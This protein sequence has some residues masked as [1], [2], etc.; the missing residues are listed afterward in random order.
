MPR[1]V[2]AD[3]L[4]QIARIH[5]TGAGT[6]EIS[7]YGA[8]AGALN[9]IGE[10][11]KPR[12][13]CVPNLRDRGAGF[14]D[15]G[16]FPTARARAPMDWP[17]GQAPERGVIEIDDIPAD[18]GIKL[19]SA[20]I[21]R[22][23]AEYHLVLVTNY[24]D[25]VLL[26]QDAGGSVE[27]RERF[28]F[29]C[30]D[31]A[32]FFALARSTK[33]PTGL[34]MRFA[35]F[36]E[37]VLLHQA[38][39][40]RPEDVAFFL[41]SYA[42]DALA[43]IEERAAIPAFANLRTALQEALGLTFDGP[44]GEHLFRSTLVQTLFYGLF[45]AWVETAREGKTFDWH[46]A[47]WTLH[48]PFIDT[49]FQQIA[50][51]GL[52]KPLG[53][54]EP[55]DWAATALARVD[56]AAFFARFDEAD[57]VRYFYEPFLAAFD[58]VLRKDMGV[59]YTPRE[60]VRY[61]VERVDRVLRTELG[62][63]DG[64]AD[65]N[66][67][68]LDPCCGTGAYLVEVLDR[69]AR[70]LREK[71]EDALLAEDLKTAATTRIAG[72]EIMPAPYVI[73]HWQMGHALRAA[74]VT[75]KDEER[76]AIYLTNALTGWAAPAENEPNDGAQKGIRYTYPPL[77]DERDGAAKVKRDRPI[78]VVLG[79]PPYNAYAGTSPREEAGLVEPYKA[80]LQADW[81][82]RK[83]NLDDLYVR[84]FRIAERR[85]A[86]GTGRGV[87]CFISNHS[88][89]WYPSFVVIRKQILEQ[90]DRI[91]IDNLNGSKFETGK[92]A[93]D[94]S[95]DP[96]MFS[97]EANREGIQV[98]TAIGLLVKH[99]GATDKRTMYRDLWGGAKREELLSSLDAADFDTQ[100]APGSPTSANRFILRPGEATADYA[101]WPKLPDLADLAPF[102]G[103]LEKRRGALLAF[104]RAELGARMQR[105]LDPTIELSTLRS[106]GIGPVEDMARFD[107]AA[108]R[109][110]IL[111]EESYSDERLRR[112]ALYPF[113][114]R[115]SYHTNVRPIWNEPRPELTTHVFEGNGFV[116]SRIRSRRPDE[117][118]PIVWTTLLAGHHLLD[119]NSCP[120]PILTTASKA[121]L[122]QPARA[123]LTA[124]G[125]PNPDRDIA[126][127]PWLHALAI[128][129]APA[130]LAENEAGIRQDWPRIPLPN[131]AAL[132][133]ASASLGA[134]VAALL[135]PDTPVL[136]VT[137]GA[138]TPALRAIAVPTKRGGGQ[139][140]RDI[141]AGWGHAGK[142]GAVMPGRG[143]VTT[144]DYAPDEADTAAQAA[145]L[146]AHANDVY[147][148][149]DALWR[150]VPD[151][152]WNF[153]IGGYLVLKKWLSYRER[154]LLGRA[155][156]P[157]EIRYVRDVA[158][159]LA[160][161]RLLGPELDANYRA[162]AAAH[163]PLDHA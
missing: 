49:L 76:A 19:N 131:S 127:L 58:P 66:V 26:G 47:G 120:I 18:I 129:Y 61:M 35:E 53:L 50:T 34:A 158:R 99:D 96:S 64:L 103:A 160:A 8:L 81:G 59:W 7:Y 118:I 46:A 1:P 126:A 22:Y 3:Y 83:F 62:L 57:A 113:D 140:D 144:R 146:G 71:G 133:R 32:A 78:L 70:T 73:A 6:G 147:L 145:L 117:G 2:L 121:N 159:R 77:A 90:F 16:L 100:Y 36:L 124:L 119:P 30:A 112:I 163:V 139:M 21:A 97:T 98:G 122:S 28:S 149:A 44:K 135:D 109:R 111:V 65:P 15:M 85:I 23:L 150:N 40:G 67:W 132:L 4:D 116:V 52:L 56:R 86:A 51:P 102:S 63:A 136:G 157:G 41:A 60:I 115:W 106:D 39:L 13:F 11:L 123:W 80:G 88:W 55:L 142:D 107:A 91:W 9:A 24:R 138:I 143:R 54:E 134:R 141:T 17:E 5:A 38:P 10:T 155:L 101:S 33:R 114:V 12:V 14:P 130:W 42:R 110:R 45:S 125:L 128:G 92:V 68:I 20:Q 37:R 148:N 108:A 95:P 89:L 48:V 79:N 72:F 27:T 94:G 84:F 137:E 93:P 151:A 87:V 105:Y 43:R 154:K 104:D 161:L 29:G 74:G 82:I 25:F 162:C 75:L 156:T 152:V 69:I 153:T 31:A